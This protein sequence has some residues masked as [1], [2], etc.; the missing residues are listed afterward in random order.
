VLV[1]LLWECA[2]IQSQRHGSNFAPSK[3]IVGNDC[4]SFVGKRPVL[5]DTYPLPRCHYFT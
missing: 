4:T 3:S 5:A 2:D 1:P